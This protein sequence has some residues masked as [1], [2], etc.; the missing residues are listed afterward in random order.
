MARDH[1]KLT[2]FDLADELTLCVYRFTKGFPAAERFGLQAQIRRA[3]VSVP[4]NIVEGCARNGERDY[5]RFLEIAFGSCRELLDLVNLSQ[6]LGFLDTDGS[7]AIETLGNRT[8][9][10]ILRLRESLDRR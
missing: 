5:L 8:A 6:R 4:A 10:A 1:R 3:A 2:A 9:G 7:S